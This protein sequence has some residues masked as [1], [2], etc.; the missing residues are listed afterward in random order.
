VFPYTLLVVVAWTTICWLAVTMLTA[1]EPEEQLVRFYRRTRPDG[2]GW[3]HIA[4]RAGGPSPGRLGGLVLDWIAGVILIYAILFGAGSVL[5]GSAII[6]LLYFTLAAA[7][8]TVIYRDL[9]RRGW[10]SVTE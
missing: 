3:K 7:A 8:G 5:L 9:S 4:A 1:P 10:K 2:P 6:A